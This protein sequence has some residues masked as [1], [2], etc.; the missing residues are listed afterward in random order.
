MLNRPNKDYTKQEKLVAEVL[1]EMGIRYQQQKRFYRK[2]L[3]KMG[4]LKNPL[5]TDIYM[6]DD[7]IVLEC[8]GNTA[9]HSKKANEKRD[10]ELLSLGVEKIIHI[11]SYEKEDIKEELRNYFGN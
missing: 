3:N 7:N 9:N 6:S 4:K 8:D 11:I 1:S 2:E 5:T 10:K